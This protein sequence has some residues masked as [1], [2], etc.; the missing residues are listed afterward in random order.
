LCGG[1]GMRIRDPENDRPKP[2]AIIGNRPILWH[3]M[4][5]YA[6]F[7]H[8]D[9]ILCLGYKAELIKEYFVEYREWE[10]NDFSLR[11]D[12]LRLHGADIADWTITFVDTGELATT[13]ERLAAVE[14]HVGGDE[15]FLAN[16]ADGLTDQWLPDHVAMV[17]ASEVA[18]SFM[19]VPTPS[20][21]H[22]ARVGDDD[23]CTAIEPLSE[24]DVWINAGFFVLRPEVFR[25]LRPGEEL[26][27]SFAGLIEERRLMA[28]RYRGF[29]RAMD[30]FK[31]QQ[32][33]EQSLRAGKA[34]WQLWERQPGPDRPIV[35][36]AER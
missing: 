16:Y 2:L 11:G 27:D 17:R 5:Y 20:S 3:L 19:V 35:R 33:F 29:W 4:K 10:S 6:Y 13:S 14:P 30:T 9:F 8:T 26:T 21:F 12:D 22:V 25:Y 24:S 32:W 23:R 1:Q 15:L 18:A 34:P 31:D 36:A 7:G 28:Y